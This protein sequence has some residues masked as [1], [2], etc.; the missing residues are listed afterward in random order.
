MKVN[1]KINFLMVMEFS[2]GKTVG[3]IVVDG[4]MDKCMDLA[5]SAGLTVID[6]KANI[7]IV[8]NKAKEH[9]IGIME[10]Y[11]LGNG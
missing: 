11:L 2:N 5:S 1:L 7:I 4:K 9:L 3:R 10:K 6:T 8:K